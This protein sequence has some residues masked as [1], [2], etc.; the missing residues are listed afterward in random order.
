MNPRKYFFVFKIIL[1]WNL[2]ADFP[3]CCRILADVKVYSGYQAGTKA[4]F[5]EF[6]KKQNPCNSL[7]YKGLSWLRGPDL[8]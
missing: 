5:E 1:E 7:N 3:S 4:I 8:N 2:E 6:S